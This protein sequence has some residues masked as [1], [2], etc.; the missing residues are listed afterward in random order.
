[1]KIKIGTNNPTK[2]E[3]IRGAFER[4]FCN[5]QI[6]AFEVN[7]KVPSQP[8]NADVF[9]GADNRIQAIKKQG[10]SEWDFLVS[11]EGGL[12]EQ[13]GHWFNVQVVK[14]E[15]RDGKTGIG[16]SQG[17]QIPDEYIEEVQRTSVAKLLDRLFQGKGG[18]SVLT[19]CFNRKQ[20][21]EDATIM[22]LTRIINGD[23]W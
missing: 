23:I 4:Y 14:I 17:F 15:N 3:A 21:I 11:C 2:I 8:L 1:M 7:S 20:L 22:A 16:L 12:L 19:G 5:L 13:Y 18:I 10:D 6:E 9:K